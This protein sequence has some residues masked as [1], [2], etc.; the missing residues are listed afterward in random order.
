MARLVAI[1]EGD[2]EETAVPLLLRRILHEIHHRYDFQIEPINAHGNTT[3]VTSLERFLEHTR[4]KPDCRGVLILLDAETLATCSRDLAYQLAQRAQKLGLPFPVAVVCATCEYESWFL[5][6]LEN[7]KSRLPLKPD[8]A[9]TGDPEQKCNAKV[10]SPNTC[11][12]G[13]FTEKLA[14]RHP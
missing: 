5:A 8:A 4:R 12:T 1:V 10:G 13:I 7:L 2:G 14:I 9:F 11:S 3:L 6:D